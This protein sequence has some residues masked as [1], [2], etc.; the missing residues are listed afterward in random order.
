MTRAVALTFVAA[1]QLVAFSSR[2]AGQRAGDIGAGPMEGTWTVTGSEQEGNPW[3]EISGATLT[4]GGGQFAL[5]FADNSRTYRGEVK[6]V[7]GPQEFDFVHREG[8]DAGRTWQALVSSNGQLLKIC[9]TYAGENPRPTT[10]TTSPGEGT[11]L[12]GLRRK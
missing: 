12:I 1:L 3:R 6:Q 7:G 11:T 4:I 5:Q 9:F 2:A 10:L 8:R